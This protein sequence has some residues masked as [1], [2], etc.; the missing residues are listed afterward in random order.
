MIIDQ[1]RAHVRI[2]YDKYLSQIIN[3]KGVSQRILFPEVLELS[4]AEAA[5]LPSISED[6]EALGFELSHLGNH[7]FGVH[8]IPS[9]IGNTDPSQLIRAMID[10]S[11]QTGNDV[12]DALRETLALS[13]ARMTAIPYGRVLTSEE[14]LLVVSELF[15]SPI[16]GYTPD[17]LKVISV[18]TDTEIDKKMQ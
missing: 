2:L 6:M 8:G 4:A 9:E 10:S 13:L 18:L 7:S 16:P 1:H 14:M 15:A 3:R 11:M 12:K 5:A 17:G